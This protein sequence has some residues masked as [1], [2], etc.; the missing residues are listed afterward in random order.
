ME[1]KERETESSSA[2]GSGGEATPVGAPRLALGPE[3]AQALEVQARGAYPE[4]CC[5]ILTGRAEPSG[6][7]V[8]S[9]LPCENVAPPADRRRRFEIDATVVLETIRSL[10]EGP[11]QLLG[12]YHSH[13]D[14]EATLS[15]T[16]M[17][18]VRLWP[19][20]VWL[21]IPVFAGDPR[22]ARA[23]WPSGSPLTVME[24]EWI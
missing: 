21:V 19:E 8:G 14:R 24:M 3:V 18:F 7:L 10:G 20:T 4:E 9:V 15:P 17:E 12:F 13:P 22:R 11:D 23:W 5:G 2:T 16:D 6:L 1:P